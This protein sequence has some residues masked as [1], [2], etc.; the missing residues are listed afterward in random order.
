[1]NILSKFDR[2]AAVLI[3][4]EVP[5]VTLATTVQVATA[6]TDTQRLKSRHQPGFIPTRRWLKCR[7][8]QR[9]R[10]GH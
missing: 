6:H 8:V 5:G 7:S 9:S 10:S 2:R 3:E 4:V 1:M